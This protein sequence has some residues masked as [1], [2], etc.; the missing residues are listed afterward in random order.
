MSFL[1]YVLLAL[2]LITLGVLLVGVILMMLGGQMNE[3]YG[4][5]LMTARVGLQGIVVLLIAALYFVGK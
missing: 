2:I 1:E 3:K 5:K 4:N